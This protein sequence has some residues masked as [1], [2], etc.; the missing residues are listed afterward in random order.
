VIRRL[1]DIAQGTLSRAVGPLAALIAAA[2]ISASFY[3]RFWYAPDDG[4]YAHIASR[5]LA[6]E[7][8][9][10]GVQD[11]HAGYVNFANAAALA[12][13]GIDFV[14]LRVPLA[15]L[16][17]IQALIVYLI[18]RRG[19]ILL[20][21]AGSL[22]VSSL[23]FVQFL[24]PTAHW[25]CLF[26]TLLIPV[27]VSRVPGPGW[28][29]LI[30]LGLVVGT[31]AMFRQLTGVIAAIAVFGWLIMEGTAP[32]VPRVWT[33]R[34]I[35]LG[36]S[37]LVGW[38]ALG[39]ADS[40][41]AALFAGGPVALLLVSG[42]HASVSTRECLR[43]AGGLAVGAVIACLPL[44]GYHIHHG[45]LSTWLDDTVVTAYQIPQLGFIGAQSFTS[46]ATLLL[47]Q[48]V[49]WSKPALILNALFWLLL[50]LLPII[51]SLTV[52]RRLQQATLTYGAAGPLM[53]CASF[54][55]LVALHYQIPIYLFYV[56]GISAA[57][58]AAAMVSARTAGRA[59][60][61]AALVCISVVA[62][63]FHAGQSL[64]R[65]VEGTIRGERGEAPVAC[66]MAHCSLRLEPR[67]AL[68]YQQ[69]VSRIEARSVPEDCILALPSDAELYFITGRC[70]PARFFN[71]A[72]GLRSDAD[73]EV[74][75]TRFRDHPPT[76]LIHRADDK[77][78]TALTRKLVESLRPRY[79]SKER[80]GAFEL[81][82]QPERTMED[83]RS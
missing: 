24:N 28:L 65:G 1:G 80:V 61:A 17:V 39:H 19:G 52:L 62:L 59:V 56:A 25:Y 78:N 51:N 70:N 81:Y 77:Y 7:V 34:V 46:F 45:S 72:L 54:Y 16:T 75:L 36:L 33:T 44:L 83:P 60:M 55:A 5:I 26:L 35:M 50:I 63:Y 82:W 42:W 4:A 47:S 64:A 38:Y 30:L 74:L 53:W 18:L 58:L 14:S 12:H 40:A 6:G 23:S 31:I 67:D 73:L 43:I 69:L 41:A 22:A 66:G 79:Q 57:A 8:L 3:D 13:F 76:V 48:F 10:S 9:N 20:A 11:V 32:G 15:I 71:S 37:A 21:F 68:V 49:H 27:I 2:V 29:R